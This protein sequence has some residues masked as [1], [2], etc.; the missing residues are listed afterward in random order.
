MV[1]IGR[2]RPGRVGC[3]QACQGVEANGLFNETNN[4][5]LVWSGLVGLGP[6][7]QGKGCNAAFIFT[8]GGLRCSHRKETSQRKSRR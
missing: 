5:F 1:C 6:A 2:A 7:C 8:N 3:G 4:L